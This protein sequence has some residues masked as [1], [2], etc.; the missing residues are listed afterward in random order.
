MEESVHFP[1]GIAKVCDWT[2]TGLPTLTEDANRRN[3][4]N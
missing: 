4:L 2:A 3:G 1:I